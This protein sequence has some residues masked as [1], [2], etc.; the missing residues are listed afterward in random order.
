MSSSVDVVLLTKNSER[1]LKQCLQSIY[2]NVPVSRLIAVDG[3]S[4]DQTLEI[5]NQFNKTHGNVK[6]VLDNGTRATAR[7][8]GI[9]CVKTD[10]F[11]FVDSDIV[12]CKDWFKKA[13]KN[14]TKDVG[15]VWGIE[16]WSTIRNLKTLRFFLILTRKIFEVRGGTH[17]TMIRTDLVK[18]IEIPEDLHVF[19]DTYIKDWIEKKGYRLIPCYSPFCIHYRPK[20]V[21]TFQGSLGLVSEAFKCGSAGLISRLM[22]AYGFYAIYSVYQLLVG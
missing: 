9:E 18:D 14:I 8:K 20:T 13:Q 21:W 17:D 6:I 11:L 19:E 7:Q 5:L 12:L 10:W 22:L 15:A 2:A 1:M 3:Y 16:I 4:K